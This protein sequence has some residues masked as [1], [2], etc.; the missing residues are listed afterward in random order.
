M[1]QSELEANTCSRR[2]AREN[3]CEQ[4]AIGFYFTSDWLRKYHKLKYFSQSQGVAMQNQSNR[5]ITFYTQLKTSQYVLQSGL[6]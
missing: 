6:N 2:K 3:A 1:N 4:V 5:E